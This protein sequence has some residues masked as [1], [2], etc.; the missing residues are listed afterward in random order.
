MHVG[1]E[2]KK[3]KTEVLRVL[4]KESER[5]TSVIKLI[6]IFDGTQTIFTPAFTYLGSI[7]TSC[8]SDT[9]DITNRVSKVNSAF[10][11][12]QSLIFGNKYLTL[13]I[14]RYLYLAI[15]INL[16]LW[17]STN[18]ALSAQM[19]PQTVK[20]RGRFLCHWRDVRVDEYFI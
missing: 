9:K 5:T 1:T 3:S 10:G 8:L 7:I 14:K 13:K 12:L 17:G 16:L 18:W 11:S 20:C 19:N 6:I 4:T 15:P 2:S